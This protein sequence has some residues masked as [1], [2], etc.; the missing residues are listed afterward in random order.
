MPSQDGADG[1]AV[2]GAR[3]GNSVDPSASQHATPTS[4]ATPTS[5]AATPT[6]EAATPTSQVTSSRAG[7]KRKLTSAVWN[8]MELKFENGEWKAECNYCHRKL[9][10]GP[11]AGT[12][13]LRSH[14]DSCPARHAPM[15]PKQQKL[16][17]TKG[18]GGK[19]SMENV[20]F[21]QEKARRDLGLM[22][23]EHEYPLSIVEHSGFRRFCTSLQPL[24]KIVC[25]NTIRNDILAMHSAQKEKMVNFFATFKHRVAVTTDLWTAGYQKRGYM[26]VTAHYIDD[27]WNLKSFLMRF[28]YVPCP[29]S[30]EVICEA[31]Y[32]CLVEWHLERKIS[33]ITLDNCTSNDK[34]M[35]ILPDKLDTS[36]LML[37][38]KLLHM[39]CAAHI[40]NLIV[41]DGMSVLEEG[42]ERVRDSVAFWSATP[43]RHEKFEKMAKTL[44]IEYNKRLTLDCKTRWNS[45]YIMI[46]IAL[47]YIE[48]FEKLKAREKKF[49]CCP[50][51]NDWKFAKEVC[52]RLKLFF[53]I[54]ESFSGT[55]YVTANLFFPKV[56]TI[57]LA[58]RK[59]GKSDIEL[60]QK[61]S[62]EMKDKFEK[63]WKDIHGLMSIAT[64]LDPRYKLHILNALYGPLYGREHAATEIEKVRKLLVELVK[65]YRDEVEGED[66]W[67]ASIAEPVGEEDEAMKLYDLYMSSRPAAPSSSIHTELDLYLEEASLPRTQELD[68]INWWK[69]SGSRFPTLQK[70]A[71][72]ILPIPITSVASE[73][74]FSTSGRVLSAHRSRLAPNVA[75]A[76]MC[77][78][79]WSRA[80]LLGGWDSTLF[81][82]FQSVLEDDEEEMDEFASIITE[83]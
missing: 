22:I 68:I 59:W 14:L 61:M 48:I 83:D 6:S 28:A 42:I 36:S 10:V 44:S 21:D 13:H 31:L 4:K 30:A 1:S 39:R 80:D 26:A 41:K 8:E 2:A 49:K 64:V 52:D 56:I 12:N 34:A 71:R 60:I 9:S 76:L 37:H 57:R 55:K 72:D 16:R 32:E 33:T 66:T 73:C 24:F 47:Q 81:A 74:A 20:I 17:L 69:V 38:G 79:A 50:T 25:R 67:D 45:T 29:H 3:N 62:E 51:K 70:L 78:Q 65:Q 58:I 46:S 53:D 63:Y 82:T 54:T 40:L 35:V 18:E 15:G 27:S 43:K 11:K 23:C 5:E 7:C 77:M 19:V 75:E